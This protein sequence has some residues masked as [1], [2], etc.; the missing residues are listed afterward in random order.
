MSGMSLLHNLKLRFKPPRIADPDFGA[1]LFMFI[2]NFP[3]RSYWECEWTFP[4][5]GSVISIGI[6]GGEEGPSS[7]A[8][9]FYLDLPGRFEEIL[10]A[11]R[12]R[13][14]EVFRTCLEQ[15]LPQDIF[16]VVKLSGFGLEDVKSRPL[17]WNISF[18]TT[19]KKWLGIVV[20]F[21]GDTAQQAIVDT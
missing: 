18:E 4:N 21:V 3:E 1:L 10:E 7:A 2:P 17:Q 14:V 8:R 16:T 12:P 19:G 9:Q 20:P 5:T 11:A 15:D 13:I 6:P